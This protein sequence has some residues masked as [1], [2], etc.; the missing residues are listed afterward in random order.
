MARPRVLVTGFGPFPGV[1]ENPSAWLAETLASQPPKID[2]ELHAKVLP[3]AWQAAELMPRLYEKLQPHVM[4]HFGV[5]QRA[6]SFR[7]ERS[8]HN[9]AAMR[10]DA[11]GALPSRPVIRPGG[12]ARFDTGLPAA[13]L[14][15]HLNTCGLAASASRSAGSYLCNYLYYHSLAWVGRQSDHRLV[16]FVHV[17]PLADQGGAL[18]KTDLLRGAQEILRF[19]VS[20]VGTPAPATTPTGRAFARSPAVVNA[21]DA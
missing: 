11:D 19:V 2:A 14:A 13:D 17:P 10:K 8:A 21:K 12:P 15:A 16:L 6:K 20:Y 9:R 5:S 7:I 3:T 1:A 18:S 4:I